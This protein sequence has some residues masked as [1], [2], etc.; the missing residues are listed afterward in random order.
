MTLPCI[1]VKE[2]IAK[3]L[4]LPSNAKIYAWAPGSYLPIAG[5]AGGDKEDA[6]LFEINI[7]D[8]SAIGQALKD[9]SS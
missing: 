5:I 3:L 2:A 6:V 8:E 7:P 9:C 1:T 4:L